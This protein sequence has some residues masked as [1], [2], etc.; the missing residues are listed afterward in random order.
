MSKEKRRRN[1][2]RRES[3]GDALQEMETFVRA[4]SAPPAKEETDC[5]AFVC[6]GE[7]DDRAVAEQVR[8]SGKALRQV[9]QAERLD[10]EELA[11]IWALAVA[12][13]ERV[14]QPP[15][16]EGDSVPVTAGK[17]VQAAAEG[18]RRAARYGYL[19]LEG[20]R[21]SILSPIWVDPQGMEVYWLL[22]DERPQPVTREMILQCLADRDVVEGIKGEAITRQVEQVR[23][24]AHSCGAIQIAAGAPPEEGTDAHVEFPVDSQRVAGKERGDGSID[25]REV[26]FAANVRAGHEL[27]RRQGATPGKPGKTVRGDVLSARD[28]CDRRLAAGENV[29]V[30]NEDGME[31][32]YATAAGALEEKDGEIA[33]VK[34]LHIAEN[35]DFRT[36]NLDFDGAICVSGSVIQGFSIKATSHVI[37]SGTVE[38]NTTVTAGGDLTVGLGIVGRKSRA[39]AK[40]TVRAQFVQEA[41]VTAGEDIVL[42]SFAYQARLRAGGSISL[43]KGTGNRRGSAIGGQLWAHES[44]QLLTAGSQGQPPTFLMA[45]VDPENVRKLDRIKSAVDGAYNQLRRLVEQFGMQR[46]DV[47]QIKNLIAAAIGARR[48]VLANKARQLGQIAQTYQQ[49]QA[50][51]RQLEQQVGAQVQGAEIR[52]YERAF[53]GVEIRLGEHRRQLTEIVLA[54]HF[55]VVGGELVDR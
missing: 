42:G 45:G 49:L 35:V 13:G 21:L 12:A 22:L 54:P 34:R 39:S 53:P 10:A 26:N 16:E 8:A 11:P 32:F 18:E 55:R 31:V 48:K 9:L 24:G 30:K 38:A 40:G 33:V 19:C 17:W 2:G 4:L 7:N 20:D 41:T 28:G 44:I 1:N 29:Q 43:E 6:P 37:V 23:K 15:G 3:R 46:L 50:A 36:G 52:I 47:G 27:A 5:F 51:C 14:G 25:F